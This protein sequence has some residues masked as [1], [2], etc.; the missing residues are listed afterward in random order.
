[1][2]RKFELGGVRSFITVGGKD[3]VF[4]FPGT[5]AA[6]LP[7]VGLDPATF[8]VPVKPRLYGLS[9]LELL[10]WDITLVGRVEQVS[11]VAGSDDLLFQA[12]LV[13]YPASCPGCRR[14][15]ISVA[16]NCG[17]DKNRLWQGVCVSCEKIYLVRS[18]EVIPFLVAPSTE[19]TWRDAT[20]CCD[21]TR[22]DSR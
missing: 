18:G 2:I 19:E 22:K 11:D 7:F 4:V 12:Y 1:M 16:I 17:G 5:I 6:M 21:G 9:V 3:D 8:V 10:A 20:R 13:A 15:L 14:E